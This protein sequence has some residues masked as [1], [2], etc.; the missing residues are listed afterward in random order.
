[1][2]DS[3]PGTGGGVGYTYSD[4][5]VSGGTEYFYVVRSSDGAACLS[6]PSNEVSAVA[7]GDCTLPPLFAG[8]ETVVNP[9]SN[10]CTLELGWSAATSRCAGSVTYNVYRSTTPGFIPDPTNQVATGVA[11]TS[12]VDASDLQ[13]QVRHYYVVR[14]VDS[15][16]GEEEQNTEERSGVPTG[17]YSIGTWIDDAGDT[18]DATL[19]PETPWSVAATGGNL[20]PTV[21]LTGTY[22]DNVCAGITTP[23]FMLGGSPSLTFWSKYQIESG[24]D[25]GVV[26]ISS[27]GGSTWAKVPVNYPGN[28]TNTSDA[29]GLPTGAY[30]TGSGTPTWAPV[31]RLARDLGQPGGDPALAAVDR[32]QRDLPGVVGRRHRHHRRAWCRPTARASRRPCSPTTSRPARPTPGA[33]WSPDRDRRMTRGRPAGRPSARLGWITSRSRSRNAARCS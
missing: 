32:R 5:D 14:A 22:G 13:S 11:G 33:P 3:S 9:A 6:D 19:T 17:P 12:F 4:Y 1:M 24:W 30:F 20:G 28:S 16:N 29:C 15:V 10:Q 8:V 26:E 21:Y 23:S 25:K 27:D 2:P 18:G 31:H 7:T